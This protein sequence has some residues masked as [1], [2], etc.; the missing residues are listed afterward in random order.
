MI[1]TKKN[2]ENILDQ[3]LYSTARKKA[4]HRSAVELINWTDM[5]ITQIGRNLDAYRK[6]GA[7]VYLDELK[8]GLVTMLAVID[9]LSIDTTARSATIE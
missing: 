4:A 9:E 7:Q 6:D 2:S 5:T 3:K 1:L 8:Y